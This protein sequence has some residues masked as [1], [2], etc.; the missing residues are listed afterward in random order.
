MLW[1]GQ[2]ID[3]LIR[4]IKSSPHP[5][6]PPLAVDEHGWLQGEGVLHIPSH[7]SWYYQRLTTHDG[8]PDAIVAHASATRVGT[9][10]SMAKRRAVPRTKEDRAASWH[11]SIEPHLI[12]QQAPLTAGCWH[13]VGNIKGVGSANRTSNGIELVGFEKGPWPPEQVD[14]A[15]RVWR[16]IVQHYDIPRDVA[17]VPHAI[18]DPERR[19][20][21]GKPWMS[22]HAKAVLDYAYA[23]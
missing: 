14:Q 2:V 8:K 7:P 19:S 10:I 9:A 17:M 15:K 12:V 22:Q 3:A 13:A 18:I 11:I 16:A 23:K 1:L 5:H 4:V 6:L 21:P 20:D